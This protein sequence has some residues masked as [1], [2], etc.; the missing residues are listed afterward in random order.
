MSTS[1]PSRRTAQ[2]SRK[3]APQPAAVV[4]NDTAT[5]TPPPVAAVAPAPARQVPYYELPADERRAI[6][7]RPHPAVSTAAQAL[8]HI[9]TC[10]DLATEAVSMAG[11]YLDDIE[12]AR[13]N[14]NRA[15]IHTPEDIHTNHRVISFELSAIRGEIM[16]T[17][18]SMSGREVRDVFDAADLLGQLTRH[19]D[20]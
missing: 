5:P 16:A 3:S 6:M 4:A 7:S 13:H 8:Q 19:P 1:K 12:A 2:A 14:P 20:L 11:Y 15:S 10:L 9:L 18:A 17:V